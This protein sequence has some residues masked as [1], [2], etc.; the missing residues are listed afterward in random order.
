MDCKGLSFS[1]RRHF[2]FHVCS[3][4]HSP[5]LS[6]PRL[7]YCWH[8]RQQL[9]CLFDVFQAESATK[10]TRGCQFSDAKAFATWSNMVPHLS[11][12]SDRSKLSMLGIALDSGMVSQVNVE[13][14]G[15]WK[16][17]VTTAEDTNVFHF[18]GFRECLMLMMFILWGESCGNQ[19]HLCHGS[20]VATLHACAVRAV[21]PLTAPGAV[22]CPQWPGAFWLG[23]VR[24]GESRV[25][26]HWISQ[27]VWKESTAL[28]ILFVKRAKNMHVFN[29]KMNLC[30]S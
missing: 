4:G 1:I 25:D 7:W 2:Q 13:L 20:V 5:S 3:P 16:S 24:P 12:F 14:P 8:L 19:S 22:A 6:E 28:F 23:V 27:A 26:L 29:R 21:R 11:C 30:D 9:W 15:N 17:I 10:T 18:E